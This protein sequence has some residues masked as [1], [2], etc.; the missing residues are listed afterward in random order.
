MPLSLSDYK[1]PP[2]D[3]GRGIAGFPSAGWKGGDRGFDYWIAESQELGIKWMRVLDDN[4]DSLVLCEKLLRAGIFPIVRILRRDLPPNDSPEP[5][6]GHIS[7]REEVTLKKFIDLGVL[8][9]ETNNEPDNPAEWKQHAVPGSL[10]ESA[11]LVAL[12]WLFDARFILEAGGYPALPAVSSGSSMDL[13]GALASLGRQ[14]ILLE[15]GWIAVHNFGHNRPLNFPNDRVNQNGVALT[16]QEYDFGPLTEWVWWDST[17]NRPNT[18]EEVNAMRAQR[19]SAGQVIVHDHAAFR[20]Y[21]YMDALAKKHL[22]RSIPIIATEGGYQ[23]GRRTDLR[24]PRI[25]PALQADLTVAMF[26]FMQRDAPEYYF[27]ACPWLMVGNSK[28]QASA[29]YSDFW[30][31]TIRAGNQNGSEIPQIP[32]PDYR[33]GDRLPVVAAVKAMTTLSRTGP[34]ITVPQPTAAAAPTQPIMPPPP[35]PPSEESV[36]LV[37]HGESLGSIAKKFSVA[38][39]ALATVNALSENARVIAG[40]RLVI[41]PPPDVMPPAMP[42]EPVTLPEPGPTPVPAK[43]SSAPTQIPEWY[44][45]PA[46]T[47]PTPAPQHAPPPQPAPTPSPRYVAPPQTSPTPAPQYSP[48]PQGAP[49]TAPQYAP[50]PRPA[51]RYVAPPPRRV[52][53][54]A[55]VLAPPS[56]HAATRAPVRSSAAD[57][58]HVRPS[59]GIYRSKIRARAPAASPPPFATGDC[60]CL[61]DASRP[62]P[63]AACARRRL[64]ARSAPRRA[65]RSRG[66]CPGQSRCDLL[67]AAARRVPGPDPIE[68]QPPYGLLAPRRQRQTRFGAARFS[69]I[70]G[71]PS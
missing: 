23:V 42:E 16:S 62:P 7:A 17:L 26:E 37:Q 2:Q 15:G 5:N 20:E 66:I 49:P 35:P 43:I 27:A 54:C 1:R 52:D 25:T 60:V 58:A 3:N 68:W 55:A 12:N 9:F 47:A 64:S 30:D 44:A 22:G 41:P 67:E 32:V 8:Y 65:E 24:Y 19:K 28:T 34:R 36:Y 69:R 63:P 18:L 4:G 6:P 50:P 53:A 29:W 38:I 13:I 39:S 14:D 45:P 11:K 51:P 21:E 61:C 59:T 56:E 31:R 71:H 48:P 10:E 70:H 40:Q 46:T 33:V 57:R